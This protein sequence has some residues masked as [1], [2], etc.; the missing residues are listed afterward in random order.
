[1]GLDGI[2]HFVATSYRGRVTIL[3]ERGH[4][5]RIET[6]GGDPQTALVVFTPFGEDALRIGLCL[7]LLIQVLH[8]FGQAV[9]RVNEGDIGRARSTT[10]SWKPPVIGVVTGGPPLAEVE[11][12]HDLAGAI[13]G[14]LRNDV[15]L[16]VSPV[17]I[18]VFAGH[19][20]RP[21]DEGFGVVPSR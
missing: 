13:A 11:G 3:V 4:S 12:P 14:D 17:F 10:R 2:S 9:V 7:P 18:A 6:R 1:S 8:F 20:V 16:C 19:F 15:A 5:R 21:M